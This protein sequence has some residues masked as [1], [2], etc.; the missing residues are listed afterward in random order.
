[1]FADRSEEEREAIKKKY[2]TEAAVAGAP[3]RI[4]AICLD[5]IDHYT[6]FILPNGFKAQVVA[7]TRE[8][9]ALYKETLDRLNAPQSAIIISG[10]EQ[11]RRATS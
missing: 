7:C 11:G 8:A 5:L 6:K 4:E 9:A 2:A 1:M 10:V 3:K